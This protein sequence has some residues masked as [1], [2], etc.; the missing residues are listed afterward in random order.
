VTEPQA[1]ACSVT[2]DQP[3]GYVLTAS[4]ATGGTPSYSY[5]WRE[6][7][8]PNTSIGTGTTYIVTNYGTYYALVKDANNCTLETNSFEYKDVTGIGDDLTN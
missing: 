7:S 8:S 1:L 2:Q 5:S 4:V 6:E 3:N